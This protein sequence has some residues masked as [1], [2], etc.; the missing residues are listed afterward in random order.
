MTAIQGTTNTPGL[1]Q[2]WGLVRFITTTLSSV[3]IRNP[4]RVNLKEHGSVGDFDET[5][6]FSWCVLTW[7]CGVRRRQ[8]R[9]GKAHESTGDGVVDREQ[10]PILVEQNLSEPRRRNVVMTDGIGHSDSSSVNFISF[11]SQCILSS[12]TRGQEIQQ[13]CLNAIKEA[14]T[15]RPT[16]PV[17]ERVEHG[18]SGVRYTPTPHDLCSQGWS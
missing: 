7:L 18:L 6:G 17:G 10:P 15:G 8:V 14:Q 13:T 3:Q 9:V 1:L 4:E 2:F 12:V 5:F 11:S 16:A